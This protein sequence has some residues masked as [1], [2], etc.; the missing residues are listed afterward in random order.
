MNACREAV[1]LTLNTLER[2][3]LIDDDLAQRDVKLD[4][5]DP[6]PPMSPALRISFVTLGARDIAV[7]RAFYRAWGWTERGGG[8]DEFVQFDAGGIRLALYPLDLLR[9]EAAPDWAALP[10]GVWN[11]FTLAINVDSRAAVD[12]THAAA[13]SAGARPVADPVER[14]WG[15]HSGYVADPEGTCWEIAWLPSWP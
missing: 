14:T 11:G 10:D 15:G 13:V 8:T 1:T 4:E 6:P 3:G 7:L 2:R 5:G 9:E 12:A